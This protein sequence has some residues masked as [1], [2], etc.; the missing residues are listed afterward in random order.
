MTTK[1]IAA[2][3]YLCQLQLEILRLREVVSGLYRAGEDRQNDVFGTGKAQQP[4][5]DRYSGIEDVRLFFRYSKAEADFF[6]RKRADLAVH[7]GDFL[8]SLTS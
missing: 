7:S 3:D 4:G 2:E 8:S 1:T 5:K 6:G